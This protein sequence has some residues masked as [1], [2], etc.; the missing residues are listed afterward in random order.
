MVTF[1]KMHGLGN[2]YICI[3]SLENILAENKLPQ[4]ARYMCNRNFGIGADGLILVQESSVADIK[5]RIFNKDGS[6]AEMCGNGI[7]CF[8]KYI[9][10]N[11]IID[12]QSISIETKAGVKGVR[13]KVL[14]GEVYEIEVDM[15]RP[16]FDDI[17]NISV[18]NNYRIPIS[19]NIKVDDT[20]FIGN[21]VSMG[22]PHLVIFVNNVENIDIEKYGP[23]IENM[24]CFP[25]KI[26]VEFV[27][28]L[29]RNT[30]KI[31]TWER[32]VGETYACGTGSCASFCIAYYKGICSSYVKAILR[33]GEL[34]LNYNKQNGHII[35][36]G[37][38]TKVYD[39]NINI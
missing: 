14:N 36:S 13:L 10:D 23:A 12:K 18:Q 24:K 9:Y 30:L 5:M 2:D 15:G 32:G 19:V 16:I 34:N 28:A 27:Q 8:A 21:Y 31:R 3:N 37:I 4:I 35:M 26:N 7:R 11:K 25:N 38:A 1:T 29:G 17:K 39:G 22:N 33:G 6:E 20:R